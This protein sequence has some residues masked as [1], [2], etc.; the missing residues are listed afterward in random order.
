[1]LVALFAWKAATLGRT[2]DVL[3]GGPTKLKLALFGAL[4]LGAWS[5]TH[6]GG[7]PEAHSPQ[8]GVAS[9]YAESQVTASGEKYSSSSMTAA[10]RTLPFG[11][12]VKVTNL[13]SN[14]SAVVRINDRG[15]YKKGRIIDVSKAAAKQLK[16]IEAGTASV[17]IEVAG[18]A[19]R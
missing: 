15:P 8:R 5:L 7:A 6:S 17:E 1:M 4:L 16:M 9:W 12:M 19:E 18:V 13:S 10:H 2:R 3:L 14:C 11:T